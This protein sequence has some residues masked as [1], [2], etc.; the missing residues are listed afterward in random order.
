MRDKWRVLKSRLEQANK[1][2]SSG[3][4]EDGQEKMQLK[5]EVEKL[6]KQLDNYRHIVQQQE[7][8]IEVGSC[9]V[10]KIELSI[11]TYFHTFLLFL[12]LLSLNILSKPLVF[13]C[14]GP[15]NLKASPISI[16]C[17]R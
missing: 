16:I 14:F 3:S 4:P 17:N 8:F 15:L 7:A 5:E 12:L 10:I 11:L 9:F 1:G 13:H 2:S 6:S